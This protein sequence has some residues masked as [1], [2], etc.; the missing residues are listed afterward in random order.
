MKTVVENTEAPAKLKNVT[1]A[2]YR[3][4]M[5]NLN[6]V[7]FEVEKLDDALSYF[8]TSFPEGKIEYLIYKP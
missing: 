6:Q 1:I 5:G 7:N 4:E 2:F 3:P 8:E